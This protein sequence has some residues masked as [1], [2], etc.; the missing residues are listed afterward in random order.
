MSRGPAAAVVGALLAVG[1]GGGA[2]PTAG[3]S[4]PVVGAAAKP[5]VLDSVNFDSLV[6]AAPRSSLV[7]FHSPT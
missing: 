7:E 6:L 5:V 4:T 1:C 2:L 3:T